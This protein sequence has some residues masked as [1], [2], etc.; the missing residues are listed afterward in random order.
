MILKSRNREEE[1]GLFRYYVHALCKFCVNSINLP[2]P[3]LI[4]RNWNQERLHWSVLM[5]SQV[6]RKPGGEL[7]LFL[8]LYPVKRVDK[9]RLRVSKRPFSL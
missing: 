9:R 3:S 2:F 5:L 7:Y 8:H 6:N 1:I 4:F